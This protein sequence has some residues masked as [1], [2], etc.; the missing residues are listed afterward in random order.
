M[1][2]KI[3]AIALSII[4]A[5]ALVAPVTVDA[6]VTTATSH[7]GNELIEYF[8]GTGHYQFNVAAG[9]SVNSK[10]DRGMSHVESM[11]QYEK[12]HSSKLPGNS[13]GGYLDGSKNEDGSIYAA[14]LV[15]ETSTIGLELPDYPITFVSGN[16]NKKMETKVEDYFF[17]TTYSSGNERRSGVIDVTDF[18]KQN[19]YGWY[20]VCNIP[21][22]TDGASWTSDQF[23][24]WKLIVIEENY[25]LP[26]RMV[27]LKL[28][29]QNVLGE[30]QVSSITINGEGIR[31]ARIND[32]TGQFLFG[33][34]GADPG[35][36]QA[37]SIRYA[38]DNAA[39]LKDL[40][41]KTF[42]TVNGV[43]TEKNPLVFISSRNGIPLSMESNFENP[44]YFKDGKY[45][46]TNENGSF[47]AG[48]GDLELLDI[49][50]TSDYYHDVKLDKNK[51]MVGFQFETVTD[52]ALM[53]T[54][55]GI[56]VDIDV[57]AYD[58]DMTINYNKDQ[59]Q[60]VVSGVMNNIT[61]LYDVGLSEPEFI[62]KY[63]PNLSLAS[64]N[65]RMTSLYSDD[66]AKV[67][68][69]L[70][71][72]EIK[73]DKD[74][75]T[76]TFKFTGLDEGEKES[77]LNK[78]NDTLYYEIILTVDTVKDY[79]ENESYVNGTLV[80]SSKNTGLYLPKVFAETKRNSL[81]GVVT[82]RNLAG[83]IIWNDNNDENHYRPQKAEVSLCMDS[84]PI[85]SIEVTG[86]GNV[87]NYSFDDLSIYKTLDYTYEYE[88]LIKKEYEN[89]EVEYQ[90]NDIIFNLKEKHIPSNTFLEDSLAG[91]NRAVTDMT[92]FNLD[93]GGLTKAYGID[94]DVRSAYTNIIV[95]AEK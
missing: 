85:D 57:P 51:S 32:V 90:D 42:S 84:V 20:Y 15:I 27:K 74:A 49:S 60:F 2:K 1:R 33:M 37:N 29:A 93:L 31:T 6:A 95:N 40:N 65:A 22:N 71:R 56:A 12:A 18:V 9:A 47:V 17:D 30:G 83:K 28:G 58:H 25:S 72:N 16:T 38:C 81:D 63:D 8:N 70:N 43:R 41:F 52:C 35:D 4:S 45:S 59:N 61:D 68:K 94:K 79:Y 48:A 13:S 69:V 10:G 14:Y 21:Y 80:S 66:S 24:G 44:V 55:L 92:P 89:Y 77:K 62:F 36:T 88:P 3:L 82:K 23:A 64:Y 75:R 86:N 87:W 53:T 78:R 73:V 34:A 76:V 54:V 67:E 19:G 50:T 26:M 11:K 7:N 39:E 91:L 46:T 5:F